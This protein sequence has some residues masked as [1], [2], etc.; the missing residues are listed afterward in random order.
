[1]LSNN[2]LLFFTNIFVWESLGILTVTFPDGFMNTILTPSFG[3]SST[4]IWLSISFSCTNKADEVFTAFSNVRDFLNR[5]GGGTFL[6]G[7]LPI[8]EQTR[9]DFDFLH[10]GLA[11][12]GV[13][14]FLLLV[15]IGVDVVVVAFLGKW[16]IGLTF[17]SSGHMGCKHDRK[18]SSYLAPRKIQLDEQ[19]LSKQ[20]QSTPSVSKVLKYYLMKSGFAW[21]DFRTEF[22]RKLHKAYSCHLHSLLRIIRS[23]IWRLDFTR[24]CF[25]RKS[26]STT[27]K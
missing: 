5:M 11:L 7:V 6:N 24:V 16:L 8:G 19:F 3:R 20:L 9:K 4:F 13:S 1:M 27:F 17:E 22:W 26:L 25:Y 12:S 15:F 18:I 10:G 21:G 23:W 2:V 14:R